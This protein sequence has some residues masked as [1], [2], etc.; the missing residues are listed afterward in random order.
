MRIARPTL[1]IR[2]DD[3]DGMSDEYERRHGLDSVNPFDAGLDGDGD[4]FRNI[5]EY[6][7]DTDPHDGSS[8]LKLL[9]VSNAPVETISFLSSTERTYS[10]L[11]TTNLLS[12]DWINERTNII[13]QANATSVTLSNAAPTHMYRI[14]A[15]VPDL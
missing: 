2:D 6:V 5:D 7:A 1:A 3:N 12:G 4:R 14:E 8:F 11:V 10:L 15:Q 13:G 9:S